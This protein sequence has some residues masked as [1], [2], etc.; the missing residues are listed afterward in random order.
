MTSLSRLLLAGLFLSLCV[1]APAEEKTAAPAL[2]FHASTPEEAQQWREKARATLFRLMMGGAKPRTVPLQ[3]EILRRIEMPAGGYVL[4]ELTLQ[5]LPDRRVHIWMAVPKKPSG[6]TGAVLAING[7]GGS[8]EEVVRGQRLYWYGRALAE[9]GYV[10]IA[11]DVGQH[12][13]QH[14][15]WTLMGER[16]WDALRC[17][18]YLETRP[19]VDP[20]RL[21]VAGL[22][23][24]GETTMYVA[25]LDERVK[26][27]CSSG[28][29]TTVENMKHGHCECF[30]FPGL[31]EHFDFSDIF[32]C[33]APRPLVLE[34]GEK[35]RAPGGF[36]VSIGQGAFEE[37]RRA[38]RVFGAED[39]ARLS[40]HP[41][42]HVF[43]G[44]DFWQPLQE[45]LGT[46]WPWGAEAS[47]ATA[48][49]TPA[50]APDKSE[51]LPPLPAGRRWKL[52]WNDEF[53]G[54]ALDPKKWDVMGDW[55]RR[56][57]FWVKED[58]L[59]DGNGH[60]LLRTKKDG[61]RYTCGAIRTLGRFEHAFG[62]WVVR[63]KFPKQPGHWPA[64][65]LMSHGVNKIGNDGRDGTE[66][67]I[68]EVPWR[69]GKITMNLHWDGYGKQHRSAGKET[70]KPELMEGF[71]TFALH[72]SSKEYVFYT[73]GQE[74]WRSSD[75]G[76]SQEPEY[77][78]LTEEIGKWAGDIAAAKLPDHFEVDYVRVYDDVPDDGKPEEAAPPKANADFARRSEIAR[79][80]FSRALGVLD[81]WWKTRDAT[82]GLYP[83]RTDQP[84]W[85][86]QDNAAD[87]LPFLVLTAHFLASERLP[88]ILDIIPKERAL[89]TR[90]AGLP[91]WFSLTTRA[92]VHP[93]PE[94]GRLIFNAAEYCKDGLIPM[95][96]VLGRG[97]WFDR[98][99]E[100]TDAIFAAA[101][102]K[103]DFGQLPADDSEV[104]GDILQVLARLH[105]ATRNAKYLQWAER[106]GDAY[107]FEV[108]PKNNGLPPHRWDFTAHAVLKDTLNLN[109]HGN[110]L[111]GGLAEL[112]VALKHADPDKAARCQ[113]PL[114]DMFHR[115]FDKARNEDGLWCNLVTASTGAVLNNS[116]PDT[117]GY[118][119]AAAHTFGTA[120][121]DAPLLDA[122]R[123]ALRHIDQPRYL[124]WGDADAYADAIEGALLLLNRMPEPEG[125][126][127]M[128]KMLP[129][130]LGKQ[131][132]DGIV[133]GWYGDG[134]YAR[135]ALMA[136]LYF[137][138]GVTCRPW[139]PDLR[140]AAVRDGN[141]LHVSLTAEK[142]WQ[143][144][145]HFDTP[146]HRTHLQLPVNCARLNEF[147]EWFTV[148]DEE[149]F[150]VTGPDG[151]QAFSGA[152]MAA[153]L[154]VSFKAGEPVT[155]TVSR[156][157]R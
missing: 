27:A 84:V 26:A 45:Q 22:S 88:E 35:E 23:L 89:T 1:K 7:H 153:G 120:A 54:T 103:S 33:V 107:C 149:R 29:L 83:R 147:P 30:N 140:F 90:Q 32:A 80:C 110:E 73:D 137:T 77:L 105:A 10:V 118:A 44:R 109:D 115:L 69:D 2:R 130:F 108:L 6:K 117:W 38:Y 74:T 60:L 48:G 146:R 56:D 154:P 16:T 20:Q 53:D 114:R 138:Q 28:W 96:E 34:L 8:G 67:D 9:M 102:V 37:I 156:S 55:K 86:P 87:M 57:G 50:A 99:V 134:N 19:E 24:G 40:V 41:G 150:T 106:I 17:L 68:V 131:R 25:A 112:F 111:I 66:I 128:D 59:L 91:D 124:H 144:T 11:P 78:K 63:C 94:L 64:F 51:T 71:H 123:Q 145:L 121:G 49:A 13:L 65:W 52:V 142:D 136:A 21:A 135:T 76:V 132:D 116:T 93:E 81:G 133:E 31:E 47:A 14:P 18:D 143:G 125:F 92:F 36:P 122:V 100:L 79:R 155:L 12:D 43:L 151:T 141:T 62:Y 70:V 119:L 4:E 39:K 97:P 82:T 127:W 85:A 98:M 42:G 3:P 75:G 104:N 129:L 126:A 157:P 15:D 72:W 101:P 152:A 5:S 95:T 113:K 148:G 61:D 58:A 46:P 139:R